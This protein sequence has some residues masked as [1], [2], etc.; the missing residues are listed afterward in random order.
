M[1]KS[2]LLTVDDV[3]M[4][5]RLGL[6]VAP[7]FSVPNHDWKPS[8]ETV[9]IQRPDGTEFEAVAQFN[10]SHF[11][12]PDPSVPLD[13]R[14]RVT[15]SILNIAK[16]EVPIGSKLFVCNELANQLLDNQA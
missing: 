9:T 2:E 12:I 1:N 10:H 6:I 15:I 3:F 16:E 5:D 4:I 7:D 8:K 11:N 13:R 14:W